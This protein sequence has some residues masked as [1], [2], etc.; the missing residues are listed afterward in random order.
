[1]ARPSIWNILMWSFWVHLVLKSQILTFRIFDD[2][3]IFG[4]YWMKFTSRFRNILRL[5]RAW[6]VTYASKFPIFQNILHN[7]AI[8]TI[9][10]NF[11]GG[12]LEFANG[13]EA[14]DRRRRGRPHPLNGRINIGLFLLSPGSGRTTVVV[15]I[16][17]CTERLRLAPM[18]YDTTFSGC[19]PSL[20]VCE[21]RGRLEVA[22]SYNSAASRLF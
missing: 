21:G 17:R 2:P 8:N 6:G 5:S 9:P 3:H 1:M 12:K 16:I 10:R 14:V 15:S 19:R 4:I 20:G 13:T 11:P 7:W 18:N 22:E